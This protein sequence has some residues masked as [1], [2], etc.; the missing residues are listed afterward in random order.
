MITS[1]LFQAFLL[2]IVAYFCVV[3]LPDPAS[4]TLQKFHLTSSEAR[5]LNL[6]ILIPMSLIWFAA[7]Y[8]SWTL[9]KYSHK[10]EDTPDGRGLRK[11][12]KGLMVLAFSLPIMA[13]IGATVGHLIAVYPEHG[14]TFR[15][16]RHIIS[17]SLTFV[18]FLWISA[19]AEE[20]S[21]RIRKRTN[22]LNNHKLLAPFLIITS[23]LFG[24]LIVAIATRYHDPSSIYSMP[25]WFVV[26]GVII[27]YLYIW[28]RGLTAV[29]YLNFYGTHVKG[30]VYRRA[31]GYLAKGFASVI[32]V[33]IVI[34]FITATSPQL[35][36]LNF[37][38]ILI[39]VYSLIALYAVGYGMIAAGAR[40]LKKIE[41]V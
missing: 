23:T 27:P 37:T 19:G 5:L 16:V 25:Q 29:Y 8:G 18:A 38:P 13:G 33:A 31:F 36:R 32:I 26:M 35:Q 9:K 14:S 11:L 28:Y 20:L 24:W 1:K 21:R 39:V 4:T 40:K 3:L 6:S 34:Q 17:I 2:I 15:V 7:F 30:H 10:I 41:E 12:A 22:L